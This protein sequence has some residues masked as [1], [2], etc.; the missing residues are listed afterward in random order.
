M[1]R[2]C[3]EENRAEAP[4]RKTD[5]NSGESSQKTVFALTKQHCDS[6]LSTQ[7]HPHTYCTIRG[8]VKCRVLSFG[9]PSSSQ[10]DSREFQINTHI[11]THTILGYF[12]PKKT[13]VYVV[14]AFGFF[15]IPRILHTVISTVYRL[16]SIHNQHRS[17]LCERFP[18]LSK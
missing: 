12:L 15:E 3:P 1:L 5:I 17:S 18:R 2:T 11:Q 10:S 6:I 13:A 7:G 4:W 9:C 16:P 8:K 14:I